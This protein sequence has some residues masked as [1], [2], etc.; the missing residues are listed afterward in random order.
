M[1]GRCDNCGSNV[2]TIPIVYIPMNED[3]Q[4]CPPC[5]KAMIKAMPTIWCRKPKGL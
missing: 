2:D 3:N 4:V 1:L 5:A